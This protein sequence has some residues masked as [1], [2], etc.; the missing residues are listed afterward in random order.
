MTILFKYTSR[1][2]PLLFLRGLDSICNNVVSDDYRVLCTFDNDDEKYRYH[3]FISDV[4][5]RKNTYI[6]WG[7]SKS[8]VDAINRDAGNFGKFDILVNFSDDQ[9]FT[10][11]GFD[12][13]IRR[14]MERLCDDLDMFIHYPDGVANERIP[15]M[16]VMGRKYYE[17]FNYIYHPDYSSLWCDNEAME[18]AKIL[19]KYTYVDTHIFKHL[20]PIWG[21]AV[22]DDQ[23]KLTESFYLRDQKVYK[24]RRKQNFF[25]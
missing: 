17:R 1:S 6:I 14:D 19:G 24:D 10:V 25:L 7:D 4:L 23:Y 22:K 18:V 11:Y 21:L 5:K 20:H 15:S 8:K 13:I 16:S 9:V 12:N 3:G 2:R